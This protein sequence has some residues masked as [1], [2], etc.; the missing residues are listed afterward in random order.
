VAVNLAEGDLGRVAACPPPQRVQHQE[1]LVRGALAPVLPDVESG[2]LPQDRV[3][4][5]R[6]PWGLVP[7]PQRKGCC[8]D[9]PP[10]RRAANRHAA[11]R[12]AVVP[13]LRTCPASRSH[14][15][16]PSSTRQSPRPL[17]QP[18][19]RTC[20]ARR[21]ASSASSNPRLLAMRLSG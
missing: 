19:A 6:A 20:R 2:K 1:R 8:G 21:L 16:N 11:T 5:H 17:S 3:A 10:S 9:R 4:A 13:G 7:P 12:S 18:A 15:S 14:P